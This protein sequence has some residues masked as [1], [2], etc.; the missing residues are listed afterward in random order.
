MQ[1][2]SDGLVASLAYAPSSGGSTRL[3][4][5]THMKSAVM[6]EKSE[7]LEP[8]TKIPDVDGPDTVVELLERMYVVLEFIH[9]E[10]GFSRAG[11]VLESILE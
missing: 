10:V 1:R 9:E 5:A 8:S 7:K 4:S 11:L 6:F 2:L 3:G